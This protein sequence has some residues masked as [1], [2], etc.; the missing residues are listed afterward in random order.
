M[1]CATVSLWSYQY[2]SM[3]QPQ[4]ALIFAQRGGDAGSWTKITKISCQ[5]N[6]LMC[7]KPHSG[8]QER[9][10]MRRQNSWYSQS[11]TSATAPK[12]S[13]TLSQWSCNIPMWPQLRPLFKV[14]FPVFLFCIPSDLPKG[15]T[16]ECQYKTNSKT[17]TNRNL[18][19]WSVTIKTDHL[20][21]H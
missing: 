5:R 11:K 12:S 21:T 13:Q 7:N 16:K 8:T 20:S 3:L 2:A 19:I 6:R 18:H 1:L 9:R 4:K 17:A 15:K 10:D 14:A